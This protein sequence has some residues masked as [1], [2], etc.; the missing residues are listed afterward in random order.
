MS[1]QPFPMLSS[2]LQRYCGKPISGCT[3]IGW[4]H[5]MPT[6]KKARNGDVSLIFSVTDDSMDRQLS[7]GPR[8]YFCKIVLYFLAS[9][10]LPTLHWGDVILIN[11]MT[12]KSDTNPK[13]SPEAHN[14]CF[15]GTKGK[16]SMQV[17]P[18]QHDPPSTTAVKPPESYGRSKELTD[19]HHRAMQLVAVSVAEVANAAMSTSALDPTA[20]CKLGRPQVGQSGV[21]TCVGPAC[22]PRTLAL[23][24]VA[25]KEDVDMLPSNHHDALL[26]CEAPVPPTSLPTQHLTSAA[27]SRP[28]ADVLAPVSGPASAPSVIP[29]SSGSPP[30]QAD[31]LSDRSIMGDGAAIA[32]ASAMLVA[33]GDH[34]RAT[35]RI[36]EDTPEPSPCADIPFAQGAS[37]QQAVASTATSPAGSARAAAATESPHRSPAG[38]EAVDHIDA[39]DRGGQ[40]PDVAS[41]SPAAL[42]LPQPASPRQRARHPPLANIG[43]R[44]VDIFTASA[45][46]PLPSQSRKRTLRGAAATL[47][48]PPHAE[49]APRSPP[50]AA[51]RGSPAPCMRIAATTS[52]RGGGGEPPH[53]DDAAAASVAAAPPQ[54]MPGNSTPS[55]S[56]AATTAP[57]AAAP[58]QPPAD[59][60]DAA[61]CP[62]NGSAPGTPVLSPMP[63]AQPVGSLPAQLHLTQLPTQSPTQV[64]DS[65]SAQVE[66]PQGQPAGP[67]PAAWPATELQSPGIPATELQLGASQATDVQA[68][69]LQPAGVQPTELQPTELQPSQLHPTEMQTAEGEPA[70]EQHMHSPHTAARPTSPPPTP[71]QG[72]DP[73]RPSPRP[74]PAQ[75]A[76]SRA[77]RAPVMQQPRTTAAPPATAIQPKGVPCRGPPAHS[78]HQPCAQQWTSS[79]LVGTPAG[80]PDAAAAAPVPSVAPAPRQMCNRAVQTTPPP[81]GAPKPRLSAAALAPAMHALPGAPQVPQGR[82]RS[83][84]SSDGP[85]AKRTRPARSS[86]LHT[87]P[88]PV[89]GGHPAAAAAAR[90]AQPLPR[91]RAPQHAL[92]PL[93]PLLPPPQRRHRAAE[94]PAA[95]AWPLSEPAPHASRSAQHERAQA[96]PQTALHSRP[97]PGQGLA[98][99]SPAAGRSRQQRV[100]DAI[101]PHA[102]VP[103]AGSAEDRAGHSGG[104]VGQ[105]LACFP[106]R[107]M[108]V[109]AIRA[110]LLRGEEP[111][112]MH[113]S[114]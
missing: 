13:A 15:F 20:A 28:A 71:L 38:A 66:P 10:D 80:A 47:E 4:V 98:V 40:Q 46:G 34:G 57:E 55:R 93:S 105:R 87:A 70:E 43:N 27:P 8:Q 30:A 12:M 81:E 84:P 32:S 36:R 53:S 91:L 97:S 29:E 113:V 56:Q 99:P 74:T 102:S 86:P 6:V 89:H 67:S 76:D 51:A 52:L 24:E 16:W 31:P 65:G 90:S 3:V 72:L 17:L 42:M 88:C 62:A 82:R 110:A 59:T 95:H 54:A 68:T 5:E 41:G 58:L 96:S 60:P 9:S 1:I 111:V 26:P 2:L 35:Q 69:E 23:C 75:P 37:C 77:A 64:R 83:A 22:S 25:V 108:S 79:R 39:G 63:E 33:P 114:P 11:G 106:G 104:G 94:A 103:A 45:N 21:G 19:Q 61:R 48:R 14:T 44:L 49:A 78:P 50:A 85:A 7:T 18:R 101:V 112:R 109:M 92:P 100:A 73:R 107:D